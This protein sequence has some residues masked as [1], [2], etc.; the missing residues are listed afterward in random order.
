MVK[1]LTV[2]VF[3]LLHIG[4]I[5]LFRRAKSQGDYLIVAVQRS[6]V[7]EKYKPGTRLYFGTDE[8]KAIVS[9]IRYV[10]E[11]IEY[12]SVDDLVKSVDFDV[13]ATGEDQTHS[14]FQ[15]AIDWCNR[16]GKQVVVLPRTEGI[17]ST[18]IRS[19]GSL[20]Y[21][22]KPETI[23]FDAIHEV[24]WSS[25]SV[26]RKEGVTQVTS[27][28]SGDELKEKLGDGKCFVALDGNH[29]VG[30]ASIKLVNNMAWYSRGVAGYFLF[31]GVLPEYQGKGVYRQLEQLRENYARSCGVNVV[32]LHTAEKNHRMQTVC[33]KYGFRKVS[34]SVSPKTNYYSIVMA[35]W[36]GGCPFSEW[37]CG[38]RYLLW[39]IYIK[40]R[41]RAGKIK[42]FV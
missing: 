13:L 35:K 22:E 16:N 8:R 6:E 20:T 2:G 9:S 5:N 26:N 29:V 38:I 19:H 28:F 21:S 42:R 32:Y 27:E 14:G 36:L 11:V 24:L 7:V 31:D 40:L 3:D 41:Y 10:D 30:T 39:S 37:Y 1:V 4:H 17:S 25:H 15:K 34:M 33:E 18:M 12:E 23:P